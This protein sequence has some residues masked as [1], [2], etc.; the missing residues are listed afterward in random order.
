MSFFH[1]LESEA[2]DRESNDQETTQVSGEKLSKPLKGLMFFIL[3]WHTL[4]I[5]SRCD[6]TREAAGAMVF[7]HELTITAR[8][9]GSQRAVGLYDYVN[10]AAFHRICAISSKTS[11]AIHNKK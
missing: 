10:T 6:H 8:R 4:T 9:G 11:A 5:V 2:K 7:S 1:C 3:E